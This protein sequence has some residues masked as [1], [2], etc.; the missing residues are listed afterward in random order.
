MDD[1]LSSWGFFHAGSCCIVLVLFRDLLTEFE[2]PGKKSLAD[3]GNCASRKPEGHLSVAA[4]ICVFGGCAMSS[5]YEE[6]DISLSSER[7]HG[8]GSPSVPGASRKVKE[9]EQGPLISVLP[10]LFERQMRLFDHP[11][12]LSGVHRTLICRFPS[13]PRRRGGFKRVPLEW[14]FMLDWRPVQPHFSSSTISYPT[15]REEMK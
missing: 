5:D 11:V 10:T 15:C 3:S 14:P 2:G 12:Q 6:F 8:V 13:R 4:W 7:V 9:P 1:R